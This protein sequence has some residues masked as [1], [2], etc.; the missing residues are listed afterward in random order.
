MRNDAGSL[1]PMA[2]GDAAWRRVLAAVGVRQH[3]CG[4]IP[5]VTELIRIAEANA[6]LHR[7]YQGRPSLH[8][9]TLRAPSSPTLFC[10]RPIPLQ[11]SFLDCRASLRLPPK[12]TR[13]HN[14]ARKD[15]LRSYARFLQCPFGRMVHCSC[16]PPSC[17]IGEIWSKAKYGPLS[18]PLWLGPTLQSDRG[19][20]PKATNPGPYLLTM[21]LQF[22]RRHANFDLVRE[23]IKRSGAYTFSVAITPLLVPF[24]TPQLDGLRG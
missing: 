5:P 17:T 6:L 16:P 22:N 7:S 3:S 15:L 21:F 9:T 20:H 19:T 2:N 8:L 4:D 12:R 24:P 14:A 10:S 23:N 13:S 1:G 11:S 18:P